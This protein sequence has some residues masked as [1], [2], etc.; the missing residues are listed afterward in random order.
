MIHGLG[1]ESSSMTLGKRLGYFVYLVRGTL[2]DAGPSVM[3]LGN[4]LPVYA[5]WLKVGLLLVLPLTMLMLTL[6]SRKPTRI[7]LSLIA[8]M[9]LGSLALTTAFCNRLWLHHAIVLLPLLYSALSLVLES[10]GNQQL[11]HLA[12]IAVLTLFLPLL[13]TNRSTARRYSNS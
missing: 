4:V 7:G 11:P 2:F 1:V 12:A 6:I 13:L 5:P 8:G 3:M 10:L 9:I